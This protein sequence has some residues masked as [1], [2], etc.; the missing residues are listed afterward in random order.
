MNV[1]IV[2]ALFDIN[3]AEKGDGRTIDQY[4][5]WFKKTLELKCDMTIYTEF[6]FKK[7]VEDSRKNSEY[8]TEI[9][10]QSLNELPFY[11]N[12]TKIYDILFS[13]KYRSTM[14]DINRIECNLPE[15]NLIQYSKFGWLKDASI[16]NTEHNYFIW[17][18]AGCSRFFNNFDLEQEWPN[19]YRLDKD[20]VTIQGNSNFVKMFDTLNIEEYIWNNNCILVGTLF[21]G[22]TEIIQI[23]NNEINNVFNFMLDKGCVNNEQFAL[24]VLAKTNP[25][26]FNVIVHLDGNH[27]P[28]FKILA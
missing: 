2:T 13:N 10:I 17:M 5:D 22:G 24:A 16:K 25:D 7:F 4:K 21:G 15:Y 19:K 23:L 3:R 12:L 9:I 28:L 20:K 8:K 18:D 1:M 14:L 26:L 27:L 11:K 6:K